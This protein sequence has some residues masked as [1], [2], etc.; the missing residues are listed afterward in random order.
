MRGGPITACKAGVSIVLPIVSRAII[1]V[2]QGEH[3]YDVYTRYL[4]A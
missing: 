1:P 4:V 3:E 2:V